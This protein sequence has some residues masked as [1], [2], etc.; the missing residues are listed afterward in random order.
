MFTVLS[1]SSRS[2]PRVAA[3]AATAFAAALV[4]AAPA[5]AEEL[6]AEPAP[7][8]AEAALDDAADALEGEATAPDAS[9][10]MN[11]LG[12]SYEQLEGAQRRR[13]RSILAR[14]TDGAADQFKDGYPAGAPVA[15]A[16]SAHFCAFWVN[17][18]GYADAPNLTDSSGDGVPDYVEQILGI[19][20]TSYG[21]EVAPGAM[22]WAPPKPDPTG[23]G[24]DP[25]ARSD[26][27]LKQLGSAGL[28]GYESPDPGQGRA[29][30]QYGY[31]VLDNDYAQSEYGYP[32]PT[33]PASVTFAH[34]F[35]HLL[36]QNYDSFQD[37]WMFESTAVWAEEQVYPDA[38]DWL[39]YLPA[40]TKRPQSPITDARASRR[41]KIY[42][43]AVWNHWL[44]RGAGYG[45]LAIRTAWEVSDVVNPADFAISSYDRAIDK[46][47]GPGFSREF[48]RFA[49]ATAEWR[50]GAGNF[51]DAASYPNVSRKGSLRRGGH[52]R[53]QL[54]HTGYALFDVKAGGGAKLRLA[55]GAEDGVRSGIA[56][57]GRNGN[58]LGGSVVRKTKYVDKGGTTTVSLAKPGRFERITAAVV[59]ADGRVRGFFR[60]DWVYSKDN[61]SFELE[62]HR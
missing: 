8:D 46:R 51:P 32:E 41:L 9:V 21:V 18:P 42:A 15:S 28:F 17:A 37:I 43:S 44:D 12:A 60:D 14:P 34:E 39:N 7:A 45:P 40:F 25:S 56:L 22:A 1:D 4:S 30:S 62:L 6:V 10:A 61:A 59:N 36:Q 16:E 50:T 5:R 52:R 35:N 27:Y 47:K 48:V 24:A 49:A 58:A 23:C 53:L 55:V 13:A 20:E 38:N 33:I 11:E 29:R 54:D 57:V 26:V 3:I 19:A 31:L 2:R